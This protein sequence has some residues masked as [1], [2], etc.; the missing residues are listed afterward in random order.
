MIQFPSVLSVQEETVVVGLMT[1][2]W[3]VTSL[4]MPRPSQKCGRSQCFV[5]QAATEPFSTVVN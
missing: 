4:G 2:G 5:V 3:R 1:M